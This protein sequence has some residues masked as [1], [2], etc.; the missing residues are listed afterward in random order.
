[1]ESAF[2][3]VSSTRL[4]VGRPGRRGIHAAGGVKRRA[5]P[6]GGR[7]RRANA[8]NALY[9]FRSPGLLHSARKK[10]LPMKRI[11]GGSSTTRGA[12]CSR[13]RLSRASVGDPRSRARDDRP[14]FRRLRVPRR[15]SLEVPPVVP[16]SEWL[17][18]P[19]PSE[20]SCGP[21]RPSRSHTARPGARRL[22]VARRLQGRP[23]VTATSRRPHSRRHRES[24][25]SRFR[26]PARIA[27]LTA[28]A[29]LR[30]PCPTES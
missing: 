19:G 12:P 22:S 23:L 5:F 30:S 18:P 25:R 9:G 2:C 7:R 1:M 15:P 21:V 3:E 13:T 28:G 4:N 16:P 14:D 11:P 17:L 10:S 20:G 6:G 27:T 26:V 8:G 29:P 24:V